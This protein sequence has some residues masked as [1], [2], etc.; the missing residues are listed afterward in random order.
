M[1]EQRRAWIFAKITLVEFR[2]KKEKKTKIATKTRPRALEIP[3]PCKWQLRG[4]E[5]FSC[6]SH[7]ENE[8]Q[9][10]VKVGSYLCLPSMSGVRDSWHLPL[11]SS[12]SRCRTGNYILRS[13]RRVARFALFARITRFEPIIR[14][15]SCPSPAPADLHTVLCKQVQMTERRKRCLWCHRTAYI[16]T[17]MDVCSKY[18]AQ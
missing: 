12:C 11:F 10:G 17:Y 13:Q 9:I 8:F 3:N 4:C 2:K 5:R 16:C 7:R 18:A 1:L 15:S 14:A 6:T